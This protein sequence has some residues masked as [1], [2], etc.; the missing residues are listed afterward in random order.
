MKLQVGQKVFIRSGYRGYMGN[1][2]KEGIVETIGKKYFTIKDRPTRKYLIENGHVQAEF[3]VSEKVYE[4]KE[5]LMSEIE[6]ENIID[7]LCKNANRYSYKNLSIE[8]LRKI[9]EII[10][11]TVPPTNETNKTK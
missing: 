8:S 11:P 2:V 6:T 7:Y 10:E 1:D 9:K 4:S 3:S 5:E